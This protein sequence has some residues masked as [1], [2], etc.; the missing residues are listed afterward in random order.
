MDR[1]APG[2][3][4]PDHMMEECF[5]FFEMKCLVGSYR[6]IDNMTVRLL[7]IRLIFTCLAGSYQ[8]VVRMTVCFVVM[9][10]WIAG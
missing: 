1:Q 3:V 7:S 4:G 2:H 8:I 6:I 5:Y 9:S 10:S